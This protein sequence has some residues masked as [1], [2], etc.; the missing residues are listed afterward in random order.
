[1]TQR[2]ALL[3]A[4]SLLFASACSTEKASSRA[5]GNA[6][7]QQAARSDADAT[8]ATVDETAGTDA[9]ASP[10]A[11]C[12]GVAA[13]EGHAYC[14][15]DDQE[16]T[17]GTVPVS[18]SESDAAV[19]AAAPAD[20]ATAAK[21]TPA[22]AAPAPVAKAPAPVVT[23]PAAPAAPAGDPKIVEFRIK[24]G[25]AKAPWNTKE[26]LVTAKIG[27]TVRIFNDDTVTHRLHTG[28]APCPHGA[29]IAPGA[30][31]DCVVTKAIDPGAGKPATYDHIAGNNASF[32][33]KTVP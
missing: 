17:L 24:A 2:S 31:A 27:Q 29:N 6:A 19:P 14:D 4:T 5:T 33:L 1:M 12:G 15:D 11:A 7:R 10:T 9:A 22:P 18:D 25:T 32:F 20:S 26:T 30:S 21:P 23:P 3:L 28:G 8:A 13:H 16:V